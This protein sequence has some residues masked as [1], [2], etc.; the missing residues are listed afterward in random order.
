MKTK[1]FIAACIILVKFLLPITSYSQVVG[2]SVTLNFTAAGVTSVKA[3][4]KGISYFAGSDTLTLNYLGNSRWSITLTDVPTGFYYYHILVN[5]APVFDQASFAYFASGTWL[6]AFEVKDTGNSFCEVKAGPYGAIRENI[7]KSGKTVRYRKCNVYTPAEYNENPSA[8]YPVVYLLPDSGENSS[9]WVYQGKI[10]HIMDNAIAADSITPMLIVLVDRN[11]Y[12][13]DGSTDSKLNNFDSSIVS[14]LIP[15]ID[16]NYQTLDSAK[17]RTIAGCS[18]GGKQALK[19]FQEHS[20][21]FDNLGIFSLPADFDTNTVDFD[22]LQ[23]TSPSVFWLGVGSND[24]SYTNVEKL[25]MG[26]TDKN[27]DHHLDIQYGSYNWL[28]WRKNL[29]YMLQELFK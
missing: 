24:E 20:D 11:E 7:F 25:H 23:I 4:C 28:A 2:D 29:Y 6:S 14:E 8:K 22:K 10:N 18:Y 19:L 13:P 5:E 15:F 27:I 12:K 9:A 16:L 1:L 17:Y 21:V 3:V 26:L